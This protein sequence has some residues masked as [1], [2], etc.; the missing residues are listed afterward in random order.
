MILL[1][2]NPALTVVPTRRDAAKLR[3]VIMLAAIALLLLRCPPIWLAPRLWAEEG[4]VYLPSAITLGFWDNLFTVQLGYYSLLDNLVI[5][6]AALFPLQYVA[7][8]TVYMAALIALIPV[9]MVLRLPSN[10]WPDLRSQCVVVLALLLLSGEEAYLNLINSQFYLATACALLLV[11]DIERTSRLQQ[12]AI[13]LLLLL[14]ALTSP[15]ACFLLPAFW[16]RAVLGREPAWRR[17]C[18]IFSGAVLLQVA[19]VTHALLQRGLQGGRGMAAAFSTEEFSRALARDI[20]LNP[21][22]RGLRDQWRARALQNIAGYLLLVSSVWIMW[23]SRRTLHLRVLAAALLLVALLSM[24]ASV[25]MAGGQRYA[26]VSSILLLL[27]VL[28]GLRQPP[29]AGLKYTVA[30]LLLLSLFSQASM[31]PMLSE[32]FFKPSWPS[33]QEALHDWHRGVNPRSEGVVI[34]PVSEGWYMP[35]HIVIDP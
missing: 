6:F 19:C 32:K 35:L 28:G 30:G 31:Y 5:G 7:H 25:D 9:V 33:W 12:V 1:E 29:H 14:S 22:F 26:Y 3:F 15:Q 4:T 11:V 8:F 17:L 16:L 23:Q 21:F 18:L 34:W 2:G 13:A 27:I 20:W 24:L 10:W